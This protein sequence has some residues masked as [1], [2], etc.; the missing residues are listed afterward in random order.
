MELTDAMALL[1][2]PRAR[3]AGND[4]VR[5]RG[6]G[7][8]EEQVAALLPTPTTD[9]ATYS[10]DGTLLPPGIASHGS[11][12]PYTATIER[13]E[14]VLGRPAPPPTEPG[15]GDRPR[16][17]PAF[18]EF[19]MGLPDGWVT[20][21]T[22][23]VPRAAQLKALGNGIVPQQMALAVRLLTPEAVTP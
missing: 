23:G 5:D 7:F 12:G 15:V 3:L 2:T 9:R 14:R 10:S 11:F 18:V 20:D 22:L 17:S 13:W 1:Q 8:L 4:V 19:L 16:L 21:P 6:H